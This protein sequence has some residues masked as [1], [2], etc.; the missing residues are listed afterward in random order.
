MSN[1]WYRKIS[2]V[3][4]ENYSTS[5]KG[6]LNRATFELPRKIN[7]LSLVLQ[8]KTHFT[9]KSY[10]KLCRKII[11]YINSSRKELIHHQ[12]REVHEEKPQEM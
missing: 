2:P 6:N 1:K 7:G 8:L 12:E 5:K 11:L 10:C 3:L 4:S 9:I